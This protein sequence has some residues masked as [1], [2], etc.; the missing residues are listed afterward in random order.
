MSRKASNTKPDLTSM[1]RSGEQSKSRILFSFSIVVNCEV[2]LEFV[3]CGSTILE[4][5]SS[6]VQ[7]FLPSPRFKLLLNCGSRKQLLSGQRDG[8]EV[9]KA[10]GTFPQERQNTELLNQ[11]YQ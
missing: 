3:R 9:L 11:H 4:T 2:V 8:G 10:V 1:T 7:M 5:K 6:R